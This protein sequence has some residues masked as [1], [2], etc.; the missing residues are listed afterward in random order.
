MNSYNRNTERKYPLNANC[1]FEYVGS[2]NIKKYKSPELLKLCEGDYF[3]KIVDARYT[4]DSEGTKVLEV[5]YDIRD[6]S[7]YYDIVNDIIKDNVLVK[8]QHL[9]LSHHVDSKYYKEFIHYMS[10][11]LSIKKGTSFNLNRIVGETE[12]AHLAYNKRDNTYHFDSRVAFCTQDMIT[13]HRM[14][15]KKN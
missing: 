13:V 5:L 8:I 14:H 4:L 12:L 9:K 2:E 7:V 6:K 15:H 1:A 3:I 10:L 11:L